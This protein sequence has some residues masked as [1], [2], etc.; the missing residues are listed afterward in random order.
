MKLIKKTLAILCSFQ[1]LFFSITNKVLAFEEKNITAPSAVL[2]DFA[3]GRVLF[4]KKSHERMFCASLGKIMTLLLAMEALENGK[5]TLNDTVI[6]NENVDSITG[7][8]VFIKSGDKLSVEDLIKA[9]AVTS[10]NDAEIVLADHIAGSENDFVS[11]MQE[12]ASELG[13]QD[14]I[15][16]NCNGV[17][18]EGQFSSAH[19]I[20]LITQELLKYPKILDY[21]S[22]WMDN[23]RDGKTQIVSS[24]KLLKNYHGVNGIKTGTTDKAGSCIS[25]SAT[26]NN[27][28]LVAVVLGCK[29]GTDRF[30][31]AVR[32]FDYG[33]KNFSCFIPEK[34]SLPFVK[35]ISGTKEF[36]C[37]KVVSCNF[38]V[39]FGKEKNIT[40]EI[41]I[42]DNI[43]APVEIH[44]SLGK[45]IFKLE[46]VVLGESNIV[47]LDNVSKLNFS[48][49]FRILLKEFLN[50]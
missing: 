40:T 15:F 17:E 22:I 28:T 16:K 20:A 37:A 1:F 46:N 42:F 2:L 43:E 13:L 8:H 33:F 7:A 21:T 38:L 32:L 23:I 35:V 24:N 5:I 41:E 50:M 45:V 44:Q 9:V 34:Q 11:E 36:V 26:N 12:K 31:D 19:D 30:N 48:S 49:A 3:S 4:E 18:E 10:A 47:A 14:T 6:A 27:F 39:P 29:T 25:A